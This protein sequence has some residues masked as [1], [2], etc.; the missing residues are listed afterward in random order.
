LLSVVFIVVGVVLLSSISELHVRED[1]VADLGLVVSFVE[2]LRDSP[3]FLQANSTLQQ[4]INKDRN[5]F[6]LVNK[7]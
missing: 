5:C 7:K 3:Q 4:N 2:A 6:L 1:S